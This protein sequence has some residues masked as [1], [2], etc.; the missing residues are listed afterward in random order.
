MVHG[1]GVWLELPDYIQNAQVLLGLL[2]LCGILRLVNFV[3]FLSASL[4]VL[5]MKCSGGTSC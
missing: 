2:I 1:H 3:D 4:G 5:R